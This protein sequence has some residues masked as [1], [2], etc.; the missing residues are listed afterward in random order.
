MPGV[1]EV[2]KTAVAGMGAALGWIQQAVEVAWVGGEHDP[3]KKLTRK[4]VVGLVELSTTM[5]WH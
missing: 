5:A 3:K 1:I 4:L 2:D